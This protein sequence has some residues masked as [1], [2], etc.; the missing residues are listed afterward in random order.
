MRFKSYTCLWNQRHLL[1]C[2]PPIWSQNIQLYGMW[3]GGGY[4]RVM[5]DLGGPLCCSSVLLLR[6]GVHIGTRELI[7]VWLYRSAILWGEGG[8]FTHSNDFYLPSRRLEEG[9]G[10]VSTL[11][12][13]LGGCPGDQYLLLRH[14]L[15]D[16]LKIRY[17]TYTST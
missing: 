10:G 2:Y 5:M 14:T 9:R 15:C 8:Y 16:I 12:G 6:G 3:E 13:G 11:G 4:L 17:G 7:M 1:Q